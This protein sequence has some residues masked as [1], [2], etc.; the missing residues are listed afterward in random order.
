[1]LNL[2]DI[3][4][5]NEDR[6]ICILETDKET[7]AIFEDEELSFADAYGWLRYDDGEGLLLDESLFRLFQRSD[8]TEL[9]QN[10]DYGL[11][12]QDGVYYRIEII[13]GYDECYDPNFYYD[14]NTIEEINDKDIINEITVILIEAYDI[15]R[16]KCS[17]SKQCLMLEKLMPKAINGV[18]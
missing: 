13:V 16:D 6:N 7:I 5:T 8:I 11:L 3:I 4:N 12:F 15:S 1:M 9:C 17:L 10:N 18:I 2:K 14:F